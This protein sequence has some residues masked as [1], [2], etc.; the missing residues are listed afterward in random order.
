MAE[1]KRNLDL[2]I[3]ETN[4][5]YREVPF[6][7]VTDWLQQGRLLAEDRVRLAGSTAWKTIADVPAFAAYLP[8]AEPTAAD[9]QA[10]ALE[11]V[12]VGF[13]S[14]RPTEEEDEDVDMIPLIDI[15]LVLLIFF[16]MTASVSSGL[17]SPI[18]TPSARF[19]NEELADK[20]WVGIDIKGPKGEV[21]K[22]ANDR[23][24][25]WF[26]LGLD[27]QQ[28]VAPSREM[29]QVTF[30]L[31]KVLQ[32]APR[33]VQVRLRADES[34]PIETIKGVTLELQSLENRLNAKREAADKLKLNIAGEVS[35]P[36]K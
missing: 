28:I 35:E 18:A 16:M 10:E 3:V 7:V 26:S 20:L 22:L 36:Q 1:K 2:W 21:E 34:L 23:P 5:V 12:E 17:L 14:H 6:S 27:Q 11:P 33:E 30:E 9:D 24:A 32:E 19:M 29:G 13:D 31:E 4:T 25:P 15:S 8:R